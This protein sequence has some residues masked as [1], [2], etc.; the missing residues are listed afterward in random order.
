MRFGMKEVRT[1]LNEQEYREFSHKRESLGLTDYGF[2][3][4]IIKN[5]FE[6]GTEETLILQKRL[7]EENKRRMKAVTCA[8][9]LLCYALAATCYILLF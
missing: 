6:N 5:H 9:L 7:G 2:L 3:K 8:Y 1:S 4:L